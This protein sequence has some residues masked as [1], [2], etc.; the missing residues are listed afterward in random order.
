MEGGSVKPVDPRPL[1]WIVAAVLLLAGCTMIDDAK[2]VEGW[3]DLVVVEHYVSYEQMRAR[4]N[5][6][7]GPGM[8]PLACAEFHFGAGECH[9]WFDEEPAQWVIE[10]ERKHCL[11]FDHVGDTTMTKMLRD[12]EGRDK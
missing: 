2:R 9:L 10:H 12:W 11:G 1:D 8:T 7:V 3:P 5:R 6:Y 4:C